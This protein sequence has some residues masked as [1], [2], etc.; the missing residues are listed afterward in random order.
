MFDR[1]NALPAGLEHLVVQLGEDIP[2][3][4]DESRLTLRRP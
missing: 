2:A 1:V 3:M 4:P